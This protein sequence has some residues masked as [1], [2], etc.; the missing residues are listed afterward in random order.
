MTFEDCCKECVDNKELVKEFNRLSGT[1]LGELRT[2]IQIAIDKACGYDPDKAAM[3][4]FIEFVRDCIWL[5]LA[6]KQN[7]EG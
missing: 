4:K 3:P 5:P 6:L 2:G 1:H 7:A